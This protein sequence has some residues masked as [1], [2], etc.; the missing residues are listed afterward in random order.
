VKSSRLLGSRHELIPRRQ[1]ATDA[2]GVGDDQPGDEQGGHPDDHAEM[3][4][5]PVSGVRKV[6]ECVMN[7]MA[8][9]T[10]KTN[11]GSKKISKG[12][13]RCDS[14]VAVGPA[15][16]RCPLAQASMLSHRDRAGQR[17]QVRLLPVGVRANRKH[18]RGHQHSGHRANR[19]VSTSGQQ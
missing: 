5:A 16:R 7:E 3:D 10:V 15:G 18:L 13:T 11:T 2:P 19:A 9:V 12:V 6:S 8:R 4:Q 17:T 1:V 14:V